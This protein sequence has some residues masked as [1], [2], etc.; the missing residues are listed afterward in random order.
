MRHKHPHRV[1]IIRIDVEDVRL[2]KEVGLQ[3]I[4]FAAVPFTSDPADAVH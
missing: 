1:R 4:V 3:Q 2:T